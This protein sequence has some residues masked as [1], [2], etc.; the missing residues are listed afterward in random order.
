MSRKMND[1][2]AGLIAHLTVETCKG[3][4]LRRALLKA[5][6]LLEGLLKME[7]LS[8]EFNFRPRKVQATT[9]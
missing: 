8:I 3:M 4:G 2:S 7:R 5:F 6:A 9:S 1:K